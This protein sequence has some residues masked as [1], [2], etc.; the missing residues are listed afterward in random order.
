MIPVRELMKIGEGGYLTLITSIAMQLMETNEELRGSVNALLEK[1]VT[2]D[3]QIMAQVI[4]L[5]NTGVDSSIPASIQKKILVE[6]VK[7]YATKEGSQQIIA[8]I[9][10]TLANTNMKVLC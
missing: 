1:I 5:I 10:R 6:L 9:I 7:N 3:N 2:N 4:V 8:N